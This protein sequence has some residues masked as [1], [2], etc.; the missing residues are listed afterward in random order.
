MKKDLRYYE[1]TDPFLIAFAEGL[2]GRSMGLPTGLNTFD[3]LTGGT[4]KETYTA[5]LGGAGTGKTTFMNY[6]RIIK[7]YLLW[8]NKLL[9]STLKDVQPRWIYFSFEISKTKMN[10]IFMAHFIVYEY[11]GEEFFLHKGKEYPMSARYL[12]GSLLDD[13][14][15]IIIVK[16]HHK[17]IVAELYQKYMI[18]LFNKEDGLIKVFDE[19][20]API[21]VYNRMLDF[22]EE[23]GKLIKE[24]YIDRKGEEKQRLVGYRPTNPNTRI[25]VLLDHIRK[26]VKNS[27]NNKGVVDDMSDLMVKARKFLKCSITIIIHNNRDFLSVQNL[28]FRKGKIFPPASSVKDSGNILEDVDLL[29]SFLN[30]N[31]AELN[32]KSHMGVDIIINGEYVNKN[33]R[34]IHL[35]KARY[36]E[37]PYHWAFDLMGAWGMIVEK[38]LK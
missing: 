9:P 18:E 4:T 12:E 31:D 6:T 15:D 26:C 13:N 21:G 14:R 35:L 11:P 23:H 22:A 20:E 17:K 34:T 1:K 28:K 29:I 27:N 2:K 8:K 25:I 38:T 24:K 7:P 16:K 30:P 19:P 5:I 10:F 32:L 33:H 36:G 37:I 3:L